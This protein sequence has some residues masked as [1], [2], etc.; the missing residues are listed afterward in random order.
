[1]TAAF[2][3]NCLSVGLSTKNC[4][5]KIL[6]LNWRAREVAAIGKTFRELYD[7]HPNLIFGLMFGDFEDFRWPT[8]LTIKGKI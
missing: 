5:L 4:T 2:F 3:G 6:S 8:L 1:M 7:V